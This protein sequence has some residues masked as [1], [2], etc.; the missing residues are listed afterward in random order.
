MQD[1]DDYVR[2]LPSVS[3]QTAGPGFAQVY[4]RGVASGGDG[5]HSGSLPSVGMY[6]DEQPITTIQ[7]ALDIHLYDIAARRGARRSAG[8]AVRRQFAGRHAAHHHQQAGSVG[9]RFE[10]QPR[11]QCRSTAATWV[12]S[13]KAFVNLPINDRSAVRLVGWYRHDAGYIDNVYRDRTF[14]TLGDHGQQREIRRRQLQRRR[15][16]WRPRSTAARPQR[17]LDHH[18]AADGPEAGGERQ[19]GVRHDRRR[20][21]AYPQLVQKHRTTAGCRPRSRSKARSPTST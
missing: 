18:A 17:Q 12:T 7:G 20:A 3:Y 21:G 5:N 9:L 1:F 8:H 19:L 2:F 13:R 16:D 10:L 4:M 14:P 11:G 15:H 6:L